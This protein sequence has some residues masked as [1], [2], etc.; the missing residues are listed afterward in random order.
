MAPFAFPMPLGSA[1]RD[2]RPRSA[3]RLV[4]LALLPSGCHGPQSMLSPHGPQAEAIAEA[5]WIMFGAACLVLVLVV[6]LALYATLQRAGRPPPARPLRIIVVGGL[7]FP[8]LALAALLVYGSM[9]SNRLVGASDPGLRIELIGHRWWWE[10]RYPDGGPPRALG[11]ELRIPSGRPVLLEMRS[12]DVIHSFWVPTLAGKLDLV[13]GRTNRLTLMADRPG[14]HLGQC[15]EFCG[16]LHAHMRIAVIAMAPDRF[17]QWRARFAPTPVPPP[18]F[19]HAGC[20]GCHRHDGQPVDGGRGPDLAGF[21]S[22]RGAPGD[23]DALARWLERRHP[24]QLRSRVADVSAPS[25]AQADALAEWLE[26][27]Q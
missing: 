27:L 15:A 16:E 14:L 23:T 7:L 5:W 11:N 12:D 20:D 22:R 2:L 19:A 26:R 4:L 6:A 1:D 17:E 25:P 18:A 3:A 8:A 10:V 21:A 24:A 9:L 13:P